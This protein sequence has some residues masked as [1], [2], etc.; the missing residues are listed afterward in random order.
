MYICELANI[1]YFIKSYGTQSQ[2]S[3]LVYLLTLLRI[4]LN[5]TVQLIYILHT[6]VEDMRVYTCL[7]CAILLITVSTL[8]LYT[9]LVCT[10]VS[11]VHNNTVEC[12]LY[13]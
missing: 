10:Y 5:S 2:L 4:N 3:I 7:R 1:M 8:I 11:P 9:L 6:C 12:T 13:K